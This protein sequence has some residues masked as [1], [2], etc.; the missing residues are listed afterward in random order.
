[1]PLMAESGPEVERVCESSGSGLRAFACDRCSRRKQRCDRQLP[2]CSNCQKAGLTCESAAKENSV[3]QLN[4][5][6]VLRKGYVRLL[7]ERVA[8]LETQV[9]VRGLATAEVTATST[10]EEETTQTARREHLPLTTYSSASPPS[11]QHGTGDMNMAFLSL[12]AMAEPQNRAGEFLRDLSMS[13]I[14][15][16]VTENYGGNPEMVGR[17]DLLW[18]RIAKNIQQTGKSSS[19]RLCLHR[20]E[21]EKSL[22]TYLII[23][24]FRYPRLPIDK[25]KR[26]MDAITTEDDDVCK[27][28]LTDNP[29]H[30][31][32]AYMVIAI[33]PLV[34][35]T[36]PVSQGSFISTHILSE[37]LKILDQVFQKEDG[38]DIIQCIHLLVAFSIHSSTAGSSWH[39]IGFAM[40]KCIALGYHREP[41][42]GTAVTPDE[43][44]EQRWAF[45]SCHL[46]DR[47]IS[48][49][50]GRPFSISDKDVTVRL[51][52]DGTEASTALSGVETVASHLFHYSMLMSSIVADH[53]EQPFESHLS[54]LLHWRTS[55]P[56]PSSTNLLDAYS[57]LTSLYHTMMLR[58]SIDQIARSHK[59]GL[60]VSQPE[61]HEVNVSILRRW[62][63][64]SD[65]AL[66][67]M[68][69][70][71]LIETCRAVIQSLN[72][73][74]MKKRSFLS[75][76]TGYSALSAALVILYHLSVSHL[77]DCDPNNATPS[78][79]VNTSQSLPSF[80]EGGSLEADEML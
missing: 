39:L 49:A 23:V 44:E 24:D 22:D 56:K 58:I 43:A 63:K 9:R 72:R 76:I 2:A 25:A 54:H 45:W 6:D 40:K 1:M 34:S 19:R 35:D 17:T 77:A 59:S 73:A 20:A 66:E 60:L 7:E 64:A 62:T 51:P 3:I 71:E 21:A 29:A 61:Y 5:R 4:D 50:L 41:P 18:D 55:T 13:R 31:F 65:Y 14:I 15:S 70:L 12:S 69:R 53:G 28:V 75:W 57:Y 27:S 11:F 80:R 16:A 46:L 38:V 67:Q 48:A 10:H 78:H 79:S 26:G 30:V 74:S 32:L 37:S 52:G 33:V 47:L 36:Y 8:G 42:A 68:K